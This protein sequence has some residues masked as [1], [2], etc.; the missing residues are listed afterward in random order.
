M[1]RNASDIG[2]AVDERP[3]VIPTVRS[4]RHDLPG[5]IS[6]CVEADA[7]VFFFGCDAS[8]IYRLRDR[9]QA[10]CPALRIAGIC[11]ADFGGATSSAVVDFITRTRPD[12]V[13][14]DM[15]DRDFRGFMQ[16]HGTRFRGISLVQMSGAFA[17]YALPAREAAPSAWLRSVSG[18]RQW[19]SLRHMC[20]GVRFACIVLA[21]LL[22]GGM[23]RIGVG[24]VAAA[25]RR[26][27]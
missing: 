18:S 14:V 20:A 21:Q 15:G 13:V 19:R 8:V 16:A 10:A 22:Q 17:T 11:D 4:R 1:S 23:S 9:V 6:R 3:S 2:I 24:R 26:D 27:G 7:S 5:F 25:M 12:V